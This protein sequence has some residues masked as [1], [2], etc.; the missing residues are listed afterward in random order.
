MIWKA[1]FMLLVLLSPRYCS[2]TLRSSLFFFLSR[3]LLY[4]A[5]N[6]SML[7][8]FTALLQRLILHLNSCRSCILC[9]LV[10][11]TAFSPVKIK[12][13]CISALL[14]ECSSL[15]CGPTHSKGGVLKTRLSPKQGFKDLQMTQKKLEKY[16]IY[17]QC[18]R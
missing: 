5:L 8:F 14:W 18:C 4:C 1:V 15:K 6:L 7:I 17:S 2:L 3:V 9:L 12:S 10:I 11:I 16:P 13:I